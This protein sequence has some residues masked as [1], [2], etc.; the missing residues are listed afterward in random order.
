MDP[1]QTFDERM[2][3]FWHYMDTK[4]MNEQWIETCVGDLRIVIDTLADYYDMTSKNVETMGTGYPK[5]AWEDRL[6]R[7]KQIQTK[8]EESTGYNRDKQIEICKKRKQVR[9]D[10]I[11]EDALV[12]MSRR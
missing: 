2:K 3:R 1:S 11:G 8:L 10:D 4:G 5:A 6:K 7:I 12:I 9:N